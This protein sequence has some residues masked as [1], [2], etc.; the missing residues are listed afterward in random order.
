[1]N[2]ISEASA[3]AETFRREDLRSEYSEANHQQ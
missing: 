1:M 2:T 3:K